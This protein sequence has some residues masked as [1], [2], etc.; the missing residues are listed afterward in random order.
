MIVAQPDNAVRRV[1]KE[2]FMRH[3]CALATLLI[4]LAAASPASAYEAPWC[5]S[6]STWK[7]CGYYTFESCVI[8]AR[9]VGGSCG[10]NPRPFDY[11]Q[12]RPSR[13]AKR[14]WWFLPH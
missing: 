9:G 1:K 8:S 3:A 7:E 10:P 11:G 5:L 4:A 2:A 13:H 6:N 14:P 12:S